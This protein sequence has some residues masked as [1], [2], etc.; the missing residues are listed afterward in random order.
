MG[1]QTV[2]QP[3]DEPVTL[4]EAKLRLSINDAYDDRDITAGIVAAR[5][6]AEQYT[7]RAFIEREIRL[8]LPL[9]GGQID[10]PVQPARSVIEVRYVAPGGVETVLPTTDYRLDSL[11]PLERIVPTEGVTW[12]P[13]ASRFDA[14]QVRY[15]A[16]YG[17]GATDVPEPIRQALLLA[18]GHWVRFQAQ[19]ESGVGPTRMPMQF[20]DLLAPYRV[21]RA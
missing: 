1:W 19:A 18:V 12:P 3:A 21:W 13:T 11:S 16:G 5:Q 8:V 20:Y 15:M 17:P 6:H 4:A 10:L 14:V 7:G 9:F 2:T